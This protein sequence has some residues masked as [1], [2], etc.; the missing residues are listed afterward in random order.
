M[1]R[2]QTIRER[3]T[4]RVTNTG[5][6]TFKKTLRDAHNSETRLHTEC[7]VSVVYIGLGMSNSCVWSLLT[8]ENGISARVRYCG[9]WSSRDSQY[10]GEGTRWR[11][12]REIAGLVVVTT[13]VAYDHKTYKCGLEATKCWFL[14]VLKEILFEICISYTNL[15][16]CL[17]ANL[18]EK[19]SPKR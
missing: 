11:L 2:Q 16:R 18:W 17:H 3:V 4:A 1:G 10:S 19:E 12:L 9:I 15:W 8:G 14:R 5:R 7:A 6:I 13:Y